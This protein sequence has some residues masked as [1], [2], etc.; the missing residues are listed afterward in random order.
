[1]FGM[2]MLKMYRRCFRSIFAGLMT[3]FILL[4]VAHGQELTEKG[5]LPKPVV[6]VIDFK[7]TVEESIA[8]QG[9]IRQVN[10]RH[11][12]IQTEIAKDTAELE[13]SKQELERQRTLLAPDAFKQRL[14]EFQSRAQQYQ[15]SVQLEQRRLDAMLG[16][17]ILVVE[18]K[19][20]EVLRDI[21]ND[22]GANIVIDAGPGRGS[23]LFSDSSLI[24]T[25][26]AKSRLDKVL[27]EVKLK[28]PTESPKGATQ[29][30]RLQVPRSQ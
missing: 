27:P 3:L 10:E 26:L 5:V 4:P 30:P 18:A 15:R 9:V 17:G 22:I 23:I 14:R 12:R 8:G 25:D 16:Q 20:T 11:K 13:R 21:A 1:M 2:R 7:R 6:A 24:I 19:L 28:E 29:T